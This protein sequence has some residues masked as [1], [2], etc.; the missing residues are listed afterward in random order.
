MATDFNINV[1][2]NGTPIVY[3]GDMYLPAVSSFSY[4]D[5]YKIGSGVNKG[6]TLEGW[7]SEITVSFETICNAEVLTRISKEIALRNANMAKG[8]LKAKS[9]Q[10][11]LDVNS[12]GAEE[13]LPEGSTAYLKSFNHGGLEVGK[14]VRG[15]IEFG[16]WVDINKRGEFKFIPTSA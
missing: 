1:P 9:F 15:T 5:P 10:V 11:I 3:F 6:V 2:K 14:E 4:D 16:V 13:M 7:D 8:D 12:L